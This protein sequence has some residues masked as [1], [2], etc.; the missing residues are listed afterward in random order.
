MS[1]ILATNFMLTSL[2]F[3]IF[4]FPVLFKM[5]EARMIILG[6]FHQSLTFM[7][8]WIPFQTEKASFAAL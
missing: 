7:C 3:S 6:F 2:L 4:T 5:K 8:V 1:D